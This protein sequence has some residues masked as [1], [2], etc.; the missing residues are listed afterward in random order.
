MKSV[1]AWRLWRRGCVSAKRTHSLP[2]DSFVRQF[3]LRKDRQLSDKVLQR[4]LVER[5][6]QQYSSQSVHLSPRDHVYAHLELSK[7]CS[8]L[9]YTPH[10]AKSASPQQV[11]PKDKSNNAAV[12]LMTSNYG[13]VLRVG[14]K[15]AKSILFGGPN[16]TEKQRAA[17]VQN[18]FGTTNM[19]HV[20]EAGGHSD[21]GG[22]Q[23]CDHEVLR[24]IR[25]SDLPVLQGPGGRRDPRQQ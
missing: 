11:I 21:P 18:Q 8:S 24:H 10:H 6:Q 12:V 20:Q 9:S 7:V 25:H 14:G 19:T 16:E 23:S 17:R 3:V 4:V 1:S 5:Y 13:L 2:Y 22:Q 15:G